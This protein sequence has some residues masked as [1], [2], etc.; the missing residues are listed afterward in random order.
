MSTVNTGCCFCLLY[1]VLKYCAAVLCIGHLNCVFYIVITGTVI[2][3]GVVVNRTSDIVL[4][5][6]EL[7]L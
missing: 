4:E 5:V 6:M 3:F 1:F 7:A 2:V